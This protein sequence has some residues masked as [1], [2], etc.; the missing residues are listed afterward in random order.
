MTVSVTFSVTQKQLPHYSGDALENVIVRVFSEDGETFVTQGTTDEDGQLILELADLTTYWVRFFLE[1]Y[2]FDPR[3]TIDVDSGASSN[4]FD[5]EGQYLAELAPSATNYLCRV[6][7]TVL[8]AHGAPVSGVRFTFSL[9]GKPRVVGGRV[10]VISDVIVESDS[11]GWVEVELVRNGSYDCVVMGLED[12]VYRVQ[13][14]DTDACRV[15]DLIWFY[16]AELSWDPDEVTLAAGDEEEVS[17]TVTLSSG[18]TTP[19]EMD[20]DD[21]FYARSFLDF[22]IADEGIATYEWNEDDTMTITGVAAGTTTITAT[23]KEDAESKREPSPTRSLA[24][25]TITVTG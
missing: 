18:T 24:S 17:P 10:M 16:I 14:P 4:E 21:W 11:D 15:T 19:F 5:V 12:T 1:E 3:L 22:A 6:Q 20:G 13:V 2:A 8:G 7:G 23:V 25:L 9:T